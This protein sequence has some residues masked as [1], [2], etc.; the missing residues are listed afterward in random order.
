MESARL[1]PYLSGLLTS[2]EVNGALS[3]FAGYDNVTIIADQARANLYV[4][5]LEARGLHSTVRA[6]ETALV[7]GIAQILRCRDAP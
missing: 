5:A 2:D 6:P 3:Q 7:A 1:G 4:N